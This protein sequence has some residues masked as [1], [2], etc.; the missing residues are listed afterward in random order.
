MTT[1]TTFQRPEYPTNRL[2][3]LS[4]SFMDFR[5]QFPYREVK[6]T[7]NI[8][9]NIIL[10]IAYFE[11]SICF[12]GGGEFSRQSP[13]PP[14]PVTLLHF[15]QALLDNCKG[16][17]CVK[18]FSENRLCFFS[19]GEEGGAT[20][21]IFTTFKP[22]TSSVAPTNALQFFIFVFPREFVVPKNVPLLGRFP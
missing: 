13:P 8:L 19:A 3:A 10:L 6:F 22:S 2:P 16:F 18:H 1:A 5:Q 7:V 11:P 9:Y 15:Y 14:H 4:S 21:A 17:V 20:F 12:C